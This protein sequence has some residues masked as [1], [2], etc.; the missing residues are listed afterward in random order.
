V[1]DEIEVS[2]QSRYLRFARLEFLTAA[3]ASVPTGLVRDALGRF[4]DSVLQK[5]SASG[6]G[7]TP[8]HEAWHRVRATEPEAEQYCRLIGALGLS[9]YDEHEEIDRIIDSIVQTPAS[10]ISDLFQASDDSNLNLLARAA[11]Q[12]WDQLLQV[13]EIDIEP[14]G[15]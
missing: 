12:L 3:T 10:I 5:M 15:H 14:G 4:V 2:A 9:P 8:A 13:R 6:F 1:G 7:G 11:Q